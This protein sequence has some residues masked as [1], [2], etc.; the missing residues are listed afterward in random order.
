MDGVF[1]IRNVVKEGLELL[2]GS[3]RG[4]TTD[5]VF[6][7][8]LEPL[9]E[10]HLTLAGLTVALDPALA[11]GFQL[12]QA[13]ERVG[14]PQGGLTDSEYRTIIAG[15]TCAMQAGGRPAGVTATWRALAGNPRDGAWSI[16]R[17]NTPGLPCVACYA[18]VD[19][20]PSREWLTR[21]G[22]VLRS[23]VGAGIE[24][25][26]V[27][28]RTDAFTLAPGGGLGFDEGALSALVQ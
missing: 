3:L 25:F 4:P 22:T 20:I 17:M 23:A 2:P 27:L 18:Q 13:G 6:G 26:G 16:K 9:A 21:A 7:A 10:I 24:V 11:T 19:T 15:R 8:V 1:P 5:A 12:R 28:Y 14:E